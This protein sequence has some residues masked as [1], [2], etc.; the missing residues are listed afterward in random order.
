MKMAKYIPMGLIF[1]LCGMNVGLLYQ[2]RELNNVAS[3]EYLLRQRAE[4]TISDG[5]KNIGTKVPI[6]SV[7]KG[8]HFIL[9]YDITTCSSCLI[10]AEA[11]LENVFGRE[12]VT[13]ELCVVGVKDIPSYLDTRISS[14]AHDS[15]LTPMDEVY[16]PYFCYVN[17]LGEVLFSLT[18]QPENYDYNRE[19]LL[20]LKRVL[21]R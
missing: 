12:M 1:V 17:D 13:K 11:L 2:S 8:H 7:S 15:I 21:N 3:N 9:R 18:M 4:W 5:I 6:D 14:V 16:S 10:E 20:K 19:I